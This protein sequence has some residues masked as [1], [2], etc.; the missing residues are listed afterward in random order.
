MPN[1][2]EI[3]AAQISNLRD[4][5]VKT[6]ERWIKSQKKI[7][8]SCVRKYGEIHYGFNALKQGFLPFI[9]REIK[10]LKKSIKVVEDVIPIRFKKVKDEH[11]VDLRFFYSQAPSYMNKKSPS[12]TYFADEFFN[13]KN[14]GNYDI[15]ICFDYKQ[16]LNTKKPLYQFENGL[17]YF[18]VRELGRALGLKL[19]ENNPE[20]T[21]Q[22][23]VMSYH[24][25]AHYATYIP[26]QMPV[27]LQLYDIVQLQSMYGVNLRTRK[28]NTYYL[29]NNNQLGQVQTLWDGRGIDTFDLSQSKFHCAFSMVGGQFSCIGQNPQTQLFSQWNFALAHIMNLENIVGSD[30]HNK[31]F[32]NDLDN[33]INGGSKDDTI[34]ITDRTIY[35]KILPNNSEKPIL[36]RL[37]KERKVNGKRYQGWGN[38][39]YYGGAGK[40]YIIFDIDQ[41][42]NLEFTKKNKHLIISHEFV[43]E[44]RKKS[45]TSTFTIA[46]FDPQKTFFLIRAKTEK[47]E[48]EVHKKFAKE[49]NQA[50][51]LIKSGEIPIPMTIVK[52]KSSLG[53]MIDRYDKNISQINGKPKILT[54]AW[55]PLGL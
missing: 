13:E 48:K 39:L 49:W 52:E 15:Y 4:K 10:L 11:N 53:Q 36:Q 29:W 51:K 35:S 22:F 21:Q 33:I 18:M 37:I 27:T 44:R 45:Y 7:T 2:E 55:I 38:D 14:V 28:E 42:Q 43:D 5:K 26:W 31:I 1:K 54:K 12:L 47:E 8:Y 46:N 40:S 32:L 50:K 17:S 23:T 3:L 25:H 34:Y 24:P 16:M 6:P 9:N 41:I 30:Y 19:H 20:I